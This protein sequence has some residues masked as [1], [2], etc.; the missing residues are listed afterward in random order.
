MSHTI[1]CS[2][3]QVNHNRNKDGVTFS[4]SIFDSIEMPHTNSK[5]A[6]WSAVLA[7]MNKQYGG[8][9]LNRLAREAKVGP[10]TS[11]RLKAQETSVGLDTLD[12]LADYFRVKP[13][14]LLIPGF[15]PDHPPGLV[16]ASVMAQDIAKMFDKITDEEQRKRAYA[17][18]VQ[19]VEFGATLEKEPMPSSAP[20][21]APQPDR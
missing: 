16:D 14:Q 10:A 9:N 19:L 6:L 11:S 3:W 13:W 20:T 21:Q 18:I 8:E 2:E 7:L 15:D 1:P 4:N 17:L 12:K 5:P